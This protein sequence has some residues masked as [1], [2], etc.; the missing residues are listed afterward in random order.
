MNDDVYK[1]GSKEW[2]KALEQMANDKYKADFY[3]K[4]YQKE[5]SAL[6]AKK[7]DPCKV[8]GAD[9]TQQILNEKGEHRALCDGCYKLIWG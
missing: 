3:S 7:L 2:Y 1:P 5:Y 4:Y 8:C 6:F 9:S